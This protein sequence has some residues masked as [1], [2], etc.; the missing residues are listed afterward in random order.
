MRK[1]IGCHWMS[2][3]I[4]SSEILPQ[5]TVLRSSE[6]KGGVLEIRDEVKMPHRLKKLMG[7]AYCL[8]RY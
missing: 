2:N 6:Y 8:D 1:V 4:V 7:G 5:M 3:K